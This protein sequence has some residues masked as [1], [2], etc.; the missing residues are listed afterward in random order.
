MFFFKF[1]KEGS[2]YI[3]NG[4]G[5]MFIIYEGE[6][7]LNFPSGLCNTNNERYKLLSYGDG[8]LYS[9]ILVI[10]K[11]KLQFNNNL[12][13]PEDW[14]LILINTQGDNDYSKLKK[15]FTC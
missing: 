4:V 9:K 12:K 11:K 8:D 6:Y 10:D 3:V 2:S 15:D 1:K 5:P 14:K 7:I 13:N